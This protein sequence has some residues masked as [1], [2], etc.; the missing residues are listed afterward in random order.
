M[1]AMDLTHS[2]NLAAAPKNGQD[3]FDQRPPIELAFNTM[4]SENGRPEASDP[5]DSC[6]DD[7][8]DDC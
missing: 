2:H 4:P 6:L 5:G 7:F 1:L 3:R 8:A